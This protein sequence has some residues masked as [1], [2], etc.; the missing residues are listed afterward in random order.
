MATNGQTDPLTARGGDAR[1]L[2]SAHSPVP[3]NSR[4]SHS[5]P[6]REDYVRQPEQVGEPAPSG[7]GLASARWAPASRAPVS[8]GK[9][10]F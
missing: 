3:S 9:A 10:H 6:K 5:A 8:G 1:A 7:P 2:R 4:S